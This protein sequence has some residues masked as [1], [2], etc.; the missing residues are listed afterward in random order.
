[1]ES[2]ST[3]TTELPFTAGE[4]SHYAGLTLVPLF[5]ASE[6]QLE[7]LGLGEALA[8]GLTVT[9]VDAD[10]AVGALQVANPLAEP[11]L[12][13]E[14]EELT[15]AKQNRIVRVTT[16]V[17]A[18]A[19]VELAVDCVER[20]RW[21]WRTQ[22]F[23]AAPRAAYPALRSE[24]H[25]GGGQAEVWRNVTAKAGRLRS[26]SPTEAQ[27]AIYA[28]HARSL[29]EYAAALPR[30]GGQSGVLV[31]LGGE[32]A[33][34][35]F[36]SRPDVFAGLYPKL[37]RGY[38]LDALEAKERAL[39]PDEARAFVARLARTASFLSVQPGTGTARRFAGDVVGAELAAYGEVVA[40]SAFPGPAMPR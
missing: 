34:L 12:L 5:P 38:A 29:D 9:E 33:C 16:L 39:G 25:R 10:G 37:L 11:V 14:G 40:L 18:H 4:S 6:P 8:R 13:Y 19:V 7:Y 2:T 23:A 30:V 22:G 24:R 20:G 31:G 36:V 1:M 15:G 3:T 21:A 32:M 26:H 27:E 17:E 28:G 35:D